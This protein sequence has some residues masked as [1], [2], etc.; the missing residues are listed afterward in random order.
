MHV[1]LQGNLRICL[2]NN[3]AKISRLCNLKTIEDAKQLRC[4]VSSKA[5]VSH[6]THNPI[7]KLIS[8]QLLSF[9]ITSFRAHRINHRCVYLIEQW[10]VKTNFLPCCMSH[11]T[12]NNLCAL[13][14]FHWNPPV[15]SF[16]CHAIGCKF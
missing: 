13:S 9:K 15:V 7:T 14:T 3:S 12:K 8:N 5:A 1:D 10:K 11:M 16:V 4:H 2:I 6:E